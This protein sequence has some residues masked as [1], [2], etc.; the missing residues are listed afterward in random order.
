MGDKKASGT[1]KT[2]KSDKQATPLAEHMADRVK[3][4][5]NQIW[6]AGLGAYSKAEEE[7]GKLF[8]ALVQDG[9]KLESRTRAMVDK[10]LSAAK[11][12]VET[13]RARATGSWEKVE[14]AFDIRVSKALNRLNIPS[15]ADV[16]QLN[17]RISELEAQLE[18][19]EKAAAKA[20]KS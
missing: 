12:K 8:D 20:S 19:I 16:D 3:E 7:G 4:S 5:A 10:P 15:R 13:V 1:D 17:Q 9:E 18:K 11:E 2:H 14:K 6:L